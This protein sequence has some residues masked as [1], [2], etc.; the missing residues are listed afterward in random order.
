[1]LPGFLA[2]ATLKVTQYLTGLG[3]LTYV[4]PVAMLVGVIVAVRKLDR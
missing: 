2:S 1:M 3:F 4:A